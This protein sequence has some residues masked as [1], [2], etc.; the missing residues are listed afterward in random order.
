MKNILPKQRNKFIDYLVLF[1]LFLG[2]SI[3]PVIAQ[4]PAVETTIQGEANPNLLVQEGRTFYKAGNFSEA[5]KTLQQAAAAFK[6]SGDE[7]RL[8][9]TLSNLSL[10]YQELG[11]WQEAKQTITESL[12]LLQETATDSTARLQLIAQAFEV[13]GKLQLT[14]GKSAEALTAWQK[15][16]EIYIQIGDKT[17]EIRS[18]VNQSLALQEL[19]LYRQALKTLIPPTHLLW[20]S[21]SDSLLKATALRALGN[22]L[23]VVGEVKEEGLK[24]FLPQFQECKDDKKLTYLDQS[25]QL[26]QQSLEISERLRSPQDSA[27]TLLGLGNTARTA[28]Y[29]A[30]DAYERAKVAHEQTEAKN[31]AEKALEYYQSAANTPDS[32]TSLTR[33]QSQL[34]QLNLLID[35]YQ[36][37]QWLFLQKDKNISET[38]RNNISRLLEN[39]RQKLPLI[40]SEIEQLPISLTGIYTR[41]NLAQNMIKL[42]SPKEEQGKFTKYPLSEQ[43]FPEYPKIEQILNKTVA[44]AQE[45]DDLRAQAYAIGNL[46]ELYEK[47][48]QLANAQKLTEKALKLTEQIQASDIAYQW[49]WQL[50]RV[51]RER[52]EI[53]GAIAA[54][55]ETIKTLD[56]LRQD[57]YSVSPETQFSF[58]DRVEPVYRQLVDLLLQPV[59]ISLNTENQKQAADEDSKLL[60][61]P[62]TN[63]EKARNVIEQ[64]QVAELED[65]LRCKLVK[66]T[67]I[68][69][70]QF[71]DQNNLQSAIIYPIILA[72]RLEVLVKLPGKAD[73]LL[74]SKPV[75]KNQIENTIEKYQKSLEN[76]QTGLDKESPFRIMYDWLIRPIE[77]DLQNNN[78]ET[79]VF[80]LDGSLRNIPM[81]AL[82]DGNNYLIEKYSIAL[83][84]GLQLQGEASW[85]QGDFKLLIGGLSESRRNSQKLPNIVK[86]VEGIIEKNP[87]SNK[88]LDEEFTTEALAEEIESEPF[89]VIHLATHGVFSSSPELTYIMAYDRDINVN[90][91]NQLLRRREESLPT[92]IELLVLSACQT[93]R[94]DKRAA[95]GIA[96]VSVEAGARSTIASLINVKDNST[97]FLMKVFYQELGKPGTTKAAALRQAQLALWNKNDE[98]NEYNEYKMP[99]YWAPFVLVGNWR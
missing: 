53:Q 46:A 39:Q 84:M 43:I 17:G 2:M 99:Y 98:Y 60:Q 32:T 3:L 68:P 52:G 44:Q 82:Y 6:M 77:A 70:D 87:H 97:S 15:A 35:Y 24:K 61:V 23:R 28:Y 72:D 57:L 29:R 73:L 63:L 34:N 27:E 55:E 20:Q 7:L 86:E 94:G 79:L 71:V 8:A 93:A 5:L 19:G 78:I 42:F 30:K 25:Q 18:Q 11:Q 81:S 14:L 21:Q 80:V 26:L 92:P 4:V 1:C 56:Q 59:S 76:K 13:N 83:N 65:F 48:G 89:S 69:I 85:Q 37:C 96:G 64:L 66:D 74:N 45:L 50:G 49:E 90:Q 10:V 12:N 95:L 16:T 22:V 47:T 33:I 75:P 62:Q 36:W 88:L 9:M 91:I 58:R 51:L 67:S 41:I 40:E 54:Y 38:E 31:Q